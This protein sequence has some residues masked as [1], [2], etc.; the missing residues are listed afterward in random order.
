MLMRWRFTASPESS[1]EMQAKGKWL[2]AL[3]DPVW[4]YKQRLSRQGE[5]NFDPSLYMPTHSYT[6]LDG[7]GGQ[8][9]YSMVVPSGTGGY[10]ISHVSMTLTAQKENVVKLTTQLWWLSSLFLLSFLDMFRW[11]YHIWG[12]EA[13]W[14]K[15]NMYYRFHSTCKLHERTFCNCAN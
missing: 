7:G 3:M 2:V 6:F 14:E 5:K 8:N 13:A 4:A 11:P 15:Y 12:C 10:C 1:L 9:V